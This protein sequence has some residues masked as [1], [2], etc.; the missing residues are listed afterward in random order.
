MACSSNF[1]NVFSVLGMFYGL[2]GGLNITLR[3]YSC[4]CLVA[5]PADVAAAAIGSEFAL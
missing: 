3:T 4:F 2:A 1:G 5:L